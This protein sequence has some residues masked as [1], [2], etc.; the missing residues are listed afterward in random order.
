MKVVLVGPFG[1]RVKGTTARRA[2]PLARALAARGHD[3]T[4]LIPPWDSPEDG[5]LTWEEGGVRIVHLVV[6]ALPSPRSGRQGERAASPCTHQADRSALLLH[7][8][9]ALS[10]AQA[11]WAER[12]A[13]V[14]LFKP[15]GHT[16][17]AHLLLWA[18][19]CWGPVRARLVVDSDDWEGPGGWNEMAGYPFAARRLFA[20]QERWGLRHADA[21][22]AASQL[23]TRRAQA[24]RGDGRVFYL[25]NGVDEGYHNPASVPLPSLPQGE[26]SRLVPPRLL[27]YTRFSEC[28]PARGLR[29]FRRLREEVPQA[30]L[31]VAGKGLRGE[32]R[33]LA[34]SVRLHGLTEAVECLGWVEAARLPALFASV[35]AAMFPMDDTTLQR[36]RCP[37][38]LADLLA[39]GVP[40]VAERVGEAASYIINGENGLLVRPGDET[41]FVAA[42]ARLLAD[43]GLRRRLREGARLRMAKEFSWTKLA[44]RAEAAYRVAG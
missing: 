32:E 1:L 37:A 34:D 26:V 15:K 19:R 36:A 12:P 2:L 14:H 7:L 17:L 28:S 44:E 5:G 23:L 33:E 30:R 9:L 16:G 8:R 6:P 18:W 22:T 41:A 10:L 43:G 29:L 31:V 21:V 3:V 40:V 25:P 11:A 20:W 39:A 42:L 24:W 4:L 13:V 27:W 38:R 35:T